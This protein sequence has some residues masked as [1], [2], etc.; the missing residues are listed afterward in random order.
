[1]SVVGVS[2]SD[3]VTK[4]AL[5][6]SVP[7]AFGSTAT[8]TPTPTPVPAPLPSGP[9]PVPAQNAGNPF[10]IGVWQQPA[11]SM[12]KWKGRGINTMVGYEDLSGPVSNEGGSAAAVSKGLYMSRQANA[13]PSKDVSQKNL[14]AW[15]LND[16]PDYH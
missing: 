5:P 13:T 14:L 1:N 2:R 11:W 8:P 12:D 3:V 10:V 9:T 15:M 6:S 4:A 16:E 7:T